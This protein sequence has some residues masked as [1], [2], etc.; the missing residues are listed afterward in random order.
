MNVQLAGIYQISDSAAVRGARE[1]GYP[2]YGTPTRSVDLD[3][4]VL[5]PTMKEVFMNLVPGV[6]PVTRGGRTTLQIY[7]EN[8]SLSLYEPLV[9]VDE[10]PI[11]DMEQF[12]SVS[13]ARIRLVD[14]IED[15]YVK[16]DLRFGGI[17]NLRS[18]DRDMAGIDLPP[19]S[20]FFDYMAIHQP[21][22]EQQDMG[23]AEDRVPDTRN[24]FLWVP[25]FQV[26]KG[27]PARIT[28]RG[29]DYPGDYVVLF[30]GQDAGGTS[31]MAETIIRVR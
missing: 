8:P 30:R 13:P 9:M 6:T 12:M 10:V 2:F 1:G 16:G 18:R 19:H 23:S 22:P 25:D 14:V 28:F 21:E 24:T 5:L 27:I 7:S 11:L 3:Q 17:V 4:Y 20:F 15:V 26:E 31:V 29:P